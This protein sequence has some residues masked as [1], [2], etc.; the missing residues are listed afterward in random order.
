MLSP[1]EEAR[2]LR[3]EHTKILRSWVAIKRQMILAPD[4]VLTFEKYLANRRANLDRVL[5]K[6]RKGS[7][8]KKPNQVSF[9]LPQRKKQGKK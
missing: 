8:G 5:G 1:L 3:D 6:G 7:K 9:P 2:I 4:I